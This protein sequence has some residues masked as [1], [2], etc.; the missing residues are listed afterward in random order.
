M[1]WKISQNNS[2]NENDPRTIRANNI[3]VIKTLED[4]SLA[5]NKL[6]S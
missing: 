2:Y 4:N 3:L 1:L 6:H 5:R